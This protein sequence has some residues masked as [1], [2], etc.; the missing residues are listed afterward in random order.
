MQPRAV[1][2]RVDGRGAPFDVD[3]E[4]RELDGHS[5]DARLVVGR[6]LLNI[7]IVDELRPFNERGEHRLGLR[8]LDDALGHGRW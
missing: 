5:G 2:A 8:G 6:D 3:I 1:T 4:Q 7:V